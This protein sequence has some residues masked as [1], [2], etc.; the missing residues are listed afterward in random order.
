MFANLPN[1]IFNQGGGGGRSGGIPRTA[2]ASVPQQAPGPMDPS[3]I[4]QQR[5]AAANMPPGAI[6]PSIIARQRMAGIAPGA[7]AGANPFW[8]PQS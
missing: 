3:I 1:N 2:T 8:T 5:I 6:D 7:L 4:A